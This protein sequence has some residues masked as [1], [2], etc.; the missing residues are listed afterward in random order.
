MRT[1]HNPIP[2]RLAYCNA[3]AAWSQTATAAVTAST[4][5][6]L[7]RHLAHKSL[8]DQFSGR[9]LKCCRRPSLHVMR[10][11]RTSNKPTTPL[12]LMPH[13]AIP[14]AITTMQ[15]TYHNTQTPP[16]PYRTCQ[17]PINTSVWRAESAATST[18]RSHNTPPAHRRLHRLRHRTQRSSSQPYVR[19]TFCLSRLY[20]RRPSPP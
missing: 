14:S 20:R 4:R 2:K 9:T 12:S 8:L 19:W 7:L 18:G 13:K 11:S 10:A 15:T 1:T 5:Q 17:E 16:H 6:L 3:H